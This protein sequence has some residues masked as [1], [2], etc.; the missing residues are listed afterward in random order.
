[1]ETIRLVLLWTAMFVLLGISTLAALSMVAGCSVVPKVQAMNDSGEPLYYAPDGSATTEKVDPETGVV[2]EPVMVYDD[3]TTGQMANRVVGTATGLIPPPFDAIAHAAGGLGIMVL[4]YFL[5]RAN[6]K[7]LEALGV[8]DELITSIE[9]DAEVHDLVRAKL[10]ESHSDSL[11][12]RVAL[13]T[14]S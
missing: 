3:E 10:S 9:S 4:L 7:K 11:K 2:R 5:R 14:E 12:A 6:R 13:V 1:M 8:A